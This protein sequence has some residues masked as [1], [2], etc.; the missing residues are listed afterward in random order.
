MNAGGGNID[1]EQMNEMVESIK[2]GTEGLQCLPFGN[3]AERIFENRQVGSHFLNLDFNRHTNVHIVRAAVEGIVFALNL[4]FEMLGDLNVPQ[5]T[6]RAGNANLFLSK[7]FREIFVNVIGVP[8]EVYDT[9]G[10]AGAA[11]GAAAQ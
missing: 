7:S 8:L 4:G 2:P 5:N 10:A 1:Y 9:D 11:R 6:I 3:G